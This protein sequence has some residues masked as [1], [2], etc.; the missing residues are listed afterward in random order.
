MPSLDIGANS[1]RQNGFIKDGHALGQE[2][3][4]RLLDSEEIRRSFD[5]V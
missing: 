1:F 3:Q 4:D 2:V 5:C